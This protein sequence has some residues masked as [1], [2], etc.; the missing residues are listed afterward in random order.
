MTYSRS[1][2]VAQTC[3]VKGDVQANLKEHVRLAHLAAAEGAQVVVFP[4]LS[5]TGYELSL[6]NALAFSEDDPR[7]SSLLDVAASRAMTLIVGAPV[8]LGSR[9]HIG[10]FVLRPDRTTELYTKHHLG[11]FSPAASCDGIV[12]PAEATVFQAGDRN[13]LVRFGGNVAAVAVCA[14]VGQSS[15]PQQAAE[16]GARTYLASMFVI[17][18]DF[19]G[20]VAKLRRYAVQHSMMVALANFG[21]P[22]GGLA[23]GGR[24]AI[25][26]ET[27]ELLVQLRVR[28]A[29]VAVVTETQ[30]GRRA[31]TVML[32]DPDL[33]DKQD[34]LEPAG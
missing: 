12:P 32:G 30:Q 20:E 22:S 11:A 26:S 34:L 28:G 29:G 14:D 1:I 31:R 3:P 33:S 9:L 23:S 15:H 4:E 5:L 10:A 6:A 13:P 19:E 17:P 25:W 27:G 16:K 18:S 24:S 7:L 8:R 2:A 21:S